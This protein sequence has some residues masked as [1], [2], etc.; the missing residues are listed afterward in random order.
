MLVKANKQGY[1]R[2]LKHLSAGEIVALPTETIY[3]LAALAHD[4]KAVTKIYTLKNRPLSKPPSICVFGKQQARKIAHVSP[5][6]AALMDA[7]W[8]GPLTL[9]L[10]IKQHTRIKGVGKTIGLR[11]PDCPWAVAFKTQGFNHPLVLTSANISGHPNP[12]N[13]QDVYK[14]FG[15]QLPL[16]L[17]GGASKTNVGS[18]IIELGE[19]GAVL[20]REGAIPPQNF[21]PFDGLSFGRAAP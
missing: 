12:H 1:E 21:A 5:L 7:F 8:P 19:H 20:L 10:P 17:D 2:A 15:D 6:A 3:G 18:T 9:V 13:A 16:I 14:A 4:D 11:H